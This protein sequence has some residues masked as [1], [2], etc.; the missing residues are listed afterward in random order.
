MLSVVAA[1]LSAGFPAVGSGGNAFCAGAGTTCCAAAGRAI[2]P[3]RSQANVP[4]ARIASAGEIRA[5]LHLPSGEAAVADYRGPAEQMMVW[6]GTA[7][8]NGISSFIRIFGCD[9]FSRPVE[10][11]FTFPSYVEFRISKFGSGCGP[12]VVFSSGYSSESDQ[13]S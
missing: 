11:D 9:D 2:V 6:S 5:T 4:K 3:T 7:H 12:R 10:P 8:S 1:A 13:N